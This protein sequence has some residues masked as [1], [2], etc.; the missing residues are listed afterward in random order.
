[1][2]VSCLQEEI[3]TGPGNWSCPAPLIQGFTAGW[4]T[5]RPNP[6][7]AWEAPALPGVSDSDAGDE[8]A[9]GDAL[10]SHAGDVLGAA[11][12]SDSDAAGVS[13]VEVE[14]LFVWLLLNRRLL[15]PIR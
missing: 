2:G 5:F 13:G 9:P 3:L 8:L 4:R 6:R 1:M 10:R 7:V 14:L 11:G 15:G 12:V